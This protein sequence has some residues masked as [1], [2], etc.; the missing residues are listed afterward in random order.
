M[1]KLTAISPIEDFVGTAWAARYA[2]TKKTVKVVAI[3]PDGLLIVENVAN[4]YTTQNKRASMLTNFTQIT[5]VT[6]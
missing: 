3:N 6:G 1:K 2:G 4:G 5:E